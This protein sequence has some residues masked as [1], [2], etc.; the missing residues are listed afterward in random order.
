MIFVRF[1]SAKKLA[2]LGKSWLFFLMSPGGP[3]AGTSGKGLS[4]KL[5]DRG[6][7]SY[8]G[9]RRSHAWGPGAPVS[10]VSHSSHRLTTPR[11]PRL[12]EKP[13]TLNFK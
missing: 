12:Q 10:A 13:E 1:P 8:S 7:Q 5:Q 6:E 3:L 4:W 11:L 2:L 9:V